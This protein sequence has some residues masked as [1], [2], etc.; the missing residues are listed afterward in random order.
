MS[1]KS[2]VKLHKTGTSVW[3]IPIAFDQRCFSWEE[4]STLMMSTLHPV[5]LP[6]LLNPDKYFQV[7]VSPM[8]V[9]HCLVKVTAHH[10]VMPKVASESRI[11]WVSDADGRTTIDF[12]Y[13]IILRALSRVQRAHGFL[14]FDLQHYSSMILPFTQ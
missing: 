13:S 11:V 10:H 5:L 3:P 12:H 4:L 8:W 6:S 9:K 2:D 1:Q 7:W 14:I